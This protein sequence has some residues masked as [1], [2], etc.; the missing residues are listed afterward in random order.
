NLNKDKCAPNYISR[1]PAIIQEPETMRV[2]KIM[3]SLYLPI[4]IHFGWNLVST[5]VFSQASLGDQLLI[6]EAGEQFSLV[7]NI[8]VMLI[9]TLALYIITF[10][11]LKMNGEQ[12][13]RSNTQPIVV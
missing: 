2:W 5:F 7:E 11:Y 8:I 1:H 12:R 9:S 3:K 6:L 4:G 13:S 10:I